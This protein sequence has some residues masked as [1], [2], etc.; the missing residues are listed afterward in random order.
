MSSPAMPHDVQKYIAERVA[1]G[2]SLAAATAE[3]DALRR[4]VLS[5][6]QAVSPPTLP[7]TPGP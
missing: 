6:R 4:T 5:P 1:A 7:G 2:A 3:I